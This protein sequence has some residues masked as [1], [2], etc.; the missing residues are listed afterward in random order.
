MEWVAISFSNAK[1]WKVKVKSLSHV[2][3]FATPWTGAYQAPPSMGFSRQEYW[4]DL[5][6][7]SSLISF[8]QHQKLINSHIFFLCV[9]F[10]LWSFWNFEIVTGTPKYHF[11]RFKFFSLVCGK[12]LSLLLHYF[13]F[14]YFFFPFFFPSETPFCQTLKFFASMPISFISFIII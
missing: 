8:H 9:V 11:V 13:V 5:Y 1:R 10:A 6:L 12:S 4:S 3:L 2:W 7:Y 14:S